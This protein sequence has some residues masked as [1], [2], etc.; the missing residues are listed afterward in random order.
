MIVL[1]AFATPPTGAYLERL[2]T[3]GV[4]WGKPIYLG[5]MD[6]MARFRVVERLGEINIPTLVTW[7]DKD[8]VIP[9]PAI[10]ETFTK[11]PR[12]SL[13]IWHGVGHSGPIEVPSRFVPLL[14]QFI[15][16]ANTPKE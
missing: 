7:G 9:F 13:E 3:D 11:I 12:C 8:A 16:E 10:M 14:T 2:V 1:G 4:R 6:D 5:M 15:R